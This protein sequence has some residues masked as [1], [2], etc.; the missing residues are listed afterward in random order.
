LTRDEEARVCGASGVSL[1]TAI[2]ATVRQSSPALLVEGAGR[3]I[4]STPIGDARMLQRRIARLHAPL[5]GYDGILLQQ[6]S[7]SRAFIAIRISILVAVFELGAIYGESLLHP[8]FA[9]T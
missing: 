4:E 8:F 6:H 5:P 1:A 7:D 3:A 9:L 2:L